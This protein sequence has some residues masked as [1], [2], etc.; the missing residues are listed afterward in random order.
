[1][2]Y[3]IIIDQERCKGCALCIGACARKLLVMAR[4]LNQKGYHFPE[5]HDPEKCSGCMNCSTMCPDAA[6]EIENIET[7]PGA[8]D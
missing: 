2:R 7:E 3:R 6:I 8:S 1:M 5:I 4:E